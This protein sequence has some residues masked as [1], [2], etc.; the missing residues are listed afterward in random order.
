[1]RK[2]ILALVLVV[3]V[4]GATATQAIKV[5]EP[6]D[7]NDSPA[8]AYETSCDPDH[9]GYMAPVEAWLC[10]IAWMVDAWWDYPW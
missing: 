5:G 8:F 4:V 10:E 2:L 6:I 3:M 1:M 7:G 9:D